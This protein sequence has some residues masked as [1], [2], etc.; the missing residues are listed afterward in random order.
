MHLLPPAA[1]LLCPLFF[2]NWFPLLLLVLVLVAVKRFSP[3][4]E[5]ATRTCSENKEF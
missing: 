1:P 3:N 2:S 4:L 5:C